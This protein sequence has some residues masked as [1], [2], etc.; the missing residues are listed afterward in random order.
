MLFVAEDFRITACVSIL[1]WVLKMYI[2]KKHR[3]KFQ[4]LMVR[5]EN[6]KYEVS[7]IQPASF[8]SYESPG[9]AYVCLFRCL[10]QHETMFPGSEV[11]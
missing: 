3:D 1:K 6:T 4:E 10:H 7:V 2:S 8:R 11:W 9:A 5:R